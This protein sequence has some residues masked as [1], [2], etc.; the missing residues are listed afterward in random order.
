LR[1][2]LGNTA[3]AFRGYDITNLGR[4][5]D[6][7]EHP[8][9]GSVV[10]VALAEGSAVCSAALGRSI[11]LVSRVRQ[12][13]E[14]EG[15]TR[16]AEDVALIV[17]VELAQMR[18]L[19]QCFGIKLNDAALVFGYSLGELAVLMAIGVY[20]MRHLLP[21]PLVLAEDC[22]DLARDVTMGVLFSRGAELDL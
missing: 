19:E 17:A 20:E 13:R 7:L 2:G 9:Y 6:L 3:F 16:Y 11:D 4:T 18:L 22:A 10:E 1:I 14:S 21:V 8:V 12:R 5:P 15:L